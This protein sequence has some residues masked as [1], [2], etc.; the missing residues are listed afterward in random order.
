MLLQAA[1]ELGIRCVFDHVGQR[2]HDLVLCVIDILQAVLVE[3]CLLA[4]GPGSEIKRIG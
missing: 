3:G 4:V 1:F 2:L